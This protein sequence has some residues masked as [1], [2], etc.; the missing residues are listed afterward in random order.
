[1]LTCCCCAELLGSVAVTV[2][3]GATV[4]SQ[5]FVQDAGSEMA[6]PHRHHDRLVACELRHGQE[7]NS[8][9]HQPRAERVPKTVPRDVRDASLLDGSLEP[10]ARVLDVSMDSSAGWQRLDGLIMW[11]TAFTREF[12]FTWRASPCFDFGTNSFPVKKFTHSQVAPYGSLRL[13]PVSRAMTNS[14]MCSG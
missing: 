12:S 1:M 4:F 5:A 7:V 14:A 13:M 3:V 11:S 9:H 6:V 10:V 2:A 8:V